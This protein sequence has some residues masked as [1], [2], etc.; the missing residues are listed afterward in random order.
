MEEY[1]NVVLLVL[2]ENSIQRLNPH[3][4]RGAKLVMAL[5][6]HHFD[7]NFFSHESSPQMIQA[8]KAKAMIMMAASISNSRPDLSAL[9]I[10]NRVSDSHVSVPGKLWKPVELCWR[11]HH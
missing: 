3:L 6:V 2:G 7:F 8:R 10:L 4:R 11:Q 1:A 9:V 5:V